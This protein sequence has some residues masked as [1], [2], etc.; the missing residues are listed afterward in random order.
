LQSSASKLFGWLSL[1]EVGFI[2]FLG[3][4]LSLSPPAPE[5]GVIE[6]PIGGLDGTLCGALTLLALPFTLWSVYYQWRV[7]KVWCTLCLGIVAVLW[8]SFLVRLPFVQWPHSVPFEFVCGYLLAVGLWFLVRPFV[9][10]E[11]QKMVV[12]RELAH[13]QQNSDLFRSFLMSQ[14]LVA[15]EPLPHEDQIGNADAPVVV[16]MVSNPNCGP[17]KE[18]Y[19]ELTNWQAY[20]ADEIQL[21]VRHINSG[22][23]KHKTHDE[24]AEQAKI[25]YTPTIY[26]N[27]RQLVEPYRAK[28]IR[29]HVRA[30]AEQQI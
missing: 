2:Y 29:Y 23:E 13:W 11:R 24:W 1:A 12:E 8:L 5:G 30:L 19:A 27:G 6:A 7:A 18:A 14:P 21:R 9:V 22:E 15:L 25:E 26:I 17:C 28:D 3:G 20:F 10:S 16:T 4:L